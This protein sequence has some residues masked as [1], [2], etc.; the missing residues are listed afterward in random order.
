MV[1][2]DDLLSYPFVRLGL[3][4]LLILAVTYKLD[5]VNA[6]YN[7]EFNGRVQKIWYDQKGIPTIEINGKTYNLFYIIWNFGRKISVGDSVI[8]IKGN[9]KIRVI[10]KESKNVSS[11]ANNYNNRLV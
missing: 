7:W 4:I 3:L 10:F 6:A 9:K 11:A 8:K 2:N 1:F 5:S